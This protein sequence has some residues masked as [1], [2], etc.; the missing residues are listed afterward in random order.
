MMEPGQNVPVLVI[1]NTEE[2][3][4]LHDR[5]PTKRKLDEIFGGY[6]CSFVA[7]P[8][9][10]VFCLI[11]TSVARMPQQMDCCGKLYCLSC[12]TESRLYSNKCPNC[13]KDGKSFPDMRSERQIKALK[14][15]C[16]NDGCK[17]R[18]QLRD[19]DDHGNTCEFTIVGCPNECRAQIQRRKLQA[20]V[21]S[22]CPKR[23]F[24][25]P[26]CKEAGM[27]ADIT[28]THLRKCPGVK[29]QCPF[30]CGVHHFR[31][32]NLQ[33]HLST[34]PNEIIPCS[35]SEI[36]CSTRLP[37]NTMKNHEQHFTNLHLAMASRAISALKN[38]TRSVTAVY[39]LTNFAALKGKFWSSPVFYAASGHA[40]QLRAYPS[41][42]LTG[43]ETHLSIMVYLMKTEKDAE[44]VWPVWANLS[45]ELL[46]QLSDEKHYEIVAKMNSSCSSQPLQRY[47]SSLIFQQFLP[48]GKLDFDHHSCQ[49]LKDDCLYF[50]ISNVEI[51]HTDKPWLQLKASE[52]KETATGSVPDS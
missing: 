3:Q 27:Y 25:C 45:V 8:P 13:R 42:I 15:S 48:H 22:T 20:H 2:L 29:I 32:K 43:T 28:T 38:K 10:D 36:G 23:M 1:N 47:H 12:L 46:N 21:Y 33:E 9:D 26:H 30:S 6:D 18:G 44:L 35:W 31:R 51:F 4:Q 24:T 11:C 16:Q 5:K 7:E 50:R 19:L 34:C 39:K 49:Y 41:G 52:Q 37:R 40:F 17:W 14:V